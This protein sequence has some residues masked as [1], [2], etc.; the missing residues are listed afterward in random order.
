[1]IVCMTAEEEV[2]RIRRQ[3]QMDWIEAHVG[4][5]DNIFDLSDLGLQQL[6]EGVKSLVKGCTC[7]K[8]K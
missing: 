7:G 4:T 2:R 8:C 5:I 1:M 6:R 3:A